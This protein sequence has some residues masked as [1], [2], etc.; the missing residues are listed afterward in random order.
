MKSR[1]MVVALVPVL[2][3]GSL[4]LARDEPPT[5]PAFPGTAQP[6]SRPAYPPIDPNKPAE[7][8]DAMH[9]MEDLLKAITAQVD[10]KAMD[11]STL[12]DISTLQIYTAFAKTALP[13]SIGELIGDAKKKAIAD[14]R[15][16]LIALLQAQIALEEAILRDDRPAARAALS[17]LA[18]QRKDAHAAYDVDDHHH[19]DQK[20]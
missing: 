13:G 16:R 17:L 4:L 18:D 8:H 11:S 7:L 12:A 2:G 5:P 3:L 10:D 20:H 15:A 19:G 9:A 14:Y 6:T 1:L